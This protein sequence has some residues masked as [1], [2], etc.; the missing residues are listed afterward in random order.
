MTFLCNINVVRKEVNKMACCK[1]TVYR[2]G[3]KWVCNG[4]IFRCERCG[5][6]GCSNEGC[7]NQRFQSNGGRCTVCGG[8]LK[9]A[10]I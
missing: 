9:K 2:N 5:A 7:T 4:Q 10:V 6:T 1:S 3:Q 8:N